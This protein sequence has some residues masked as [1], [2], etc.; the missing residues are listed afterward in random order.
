V[1]ALLIWLVRGYR[2]AISPLFP[3]RCRFLPSCSDYALQA[4]E[5]HGICAGCWL[6]LCRFVRCNPL[7]PGGIDEVPEQAS[8]WFASC[9][10]ARHFKESHR[11]G[12][13]RFRC[14]CRPSSSRS[15][16]PSANR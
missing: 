16:T 2:L 10:D 9:G 15:T 1:K 13:R 11:E 14:R 3:P 6:A 8:D 5:R 7:N 12:G 4:I